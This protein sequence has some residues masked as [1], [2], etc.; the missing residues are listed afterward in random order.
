MICNG[1]AR[2]FGPQL[3]HY[4]V[5]SDKNDTSEVLFLSREKTLAEEI[6]HMEAD[7]RG[8]RCKKPLYHAQVRSQDGEHLTQQQ[9]LR[10]A[11][12]YAE[13]MGFVGLPYA[14]VLHRF[15]GHDHLHIVWGRID[16][17]TGHAR[18]YK[19][20]YAKQEKAARRMEE[21]FGLARTRGR[22]Y[23]ENGQSYTDQDDRKRSHRKTNK[24]EQG[25][26]ERSGIDP[27]AR[28]DHITS[29][30]HYTTTGRE[31]RSMLAASG[32]TLARGDRRDYVVVDG[33]G[34]A[35][36]LARQIRGVKAAEI[37]A[38]MVDVS[39]SELPSVAEVRKQMRI[40]AG[41]A[42]KERQ[43]QTRAE[44]QR[45]FSPAETGE[46]VTPRV[47]RTPHRETPEP[48]RAPQPRNIQQP[49]Y[50]SPSVATP[51]VSRLGRLPDPVVPTSGRASVQASAGSGSPE[52]A[53]PRNRKP[54]DLLRDMN[55]RPA[56]PSRAE[57]LNVHR[58]AQQ[59]EGGAFSAGDIEAQK[60]KLDEAAPGTQEYAMRR[61]R[62]DFMLRKRADRNQNQP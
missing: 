34:E 49:V 47:T 44:A 7:A 1:K 14:A 27:N 24:A 32:Y 9:M 5:K 10:A 43:E 22:F 26:Q 2:S 37:R 29:L 51:R 55:P 45:P 48:S 59:V 50:R 35:H 31:F 13:E 11:N 33:K 18:D 25:Q 36:S 17:E 38:R 52:P 28:K 3:V 53:P 42:R 8:S 39:P 62:L 54:A 46:T 41:E 30:W 61:E 40:A 56:E 15:K 21:E 16:P 60:A 23:D 57:R 19:N 12:I 58:T 20:D 6:A 4:L